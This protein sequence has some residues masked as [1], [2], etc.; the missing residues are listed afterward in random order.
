M[1]LP[2]FYIYAT[3]HQTAAAVVAADYLVLAMNPKNMAV[4]EYD[5]SGFNSFAYFNGHYLGA[6]AGTI[7]VL[8]GDDDAGSIIESEIEFGQIPVDLVKPRDVYVLGRA[9]GMMAL[10]VQA[11]EDT[12]KEVNIAYMLETLNLD[13]AKIPRGL[14][15]TYFSLKLENK[16]G[17]DFDIDEIQVWGEVLGRGKP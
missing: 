15:P 3:G 9:D 7:H 16:N 12:E 1:D 11:D 2:M 4:S 5:W 6:K 17:S 14:Q 10:T 13:R 8:G